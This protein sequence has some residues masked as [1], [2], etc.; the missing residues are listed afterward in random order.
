MVIYEVIWLSYLLVPG[1]H[2]QLMCSAVFVNPRS[3][4]LC[5]SF[6][7]MIQWFFHTLPPR[8]WW[9]AAGGESVTCLSGFPL[10]VQRCD[11]SSE[12]PCAWP[13]ASWAQSQR[14]QLLQWAATP[15][16]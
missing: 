8:N 6:G 15:V 12:R 2:E 16:P 1:G 4:R 3:A 9:G 14:Q 5:L 10:R 11:L 13:S 7:R